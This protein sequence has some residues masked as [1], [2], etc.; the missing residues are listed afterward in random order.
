VLTL[1]P[2][3]IFQ[4][5][6]VRSLSSSSGQAAIAYL[7]SVAQLVWHTRNLDHSLADL[8]QI[9]THHSPLLE[10]RTSN[11]LPAFFLTLTLLLD[12][13]VYSAVSHNLPRITNNVF[14]PS[15]ERSPLA[16]LTDP[17]LT[18]YAELS[19]TI[20]MH[21]R[22]G[23]YEGHCWIL[24]HYSAPYA[25][26]NVLP[27]LPDVYKPPPGGENA[28]DDAKNALMP[29]CL[30]DVNTVVGRLKDVVREYAEKNPDKPKLEEV[31][32]MTNANDD[33]IN[34]LRTEL[35]KIG[36]PRMMTSKELELRDGEKFASMVSRCNVRPVRDSNWLLSRSLIWKLVF[37]RHSSL[38]TG[39]AH[40]Q[41]S[42]YRMTYL[43]MQYSTFTSTI[44]AL[45]AA[46]GAP[47]HNSRFW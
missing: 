40:L 45:R 29:H 41:T 12:Q 23:D 14:T 47:L 30:P 8:L 32:L 25:S 46:R 6:L 7:L 28:P 31:F 34:P 19:N 16:R 36:L 2:E 43:L 37:A 22:R 24:R 11:F 33:F 15:T 13:A 1:L 5:R 3:R 17:P 21:I 26:F 44:V 20:S 35:A 42:E 39:Y 9:T 18:A 38:A 27:G 10:R 4:H